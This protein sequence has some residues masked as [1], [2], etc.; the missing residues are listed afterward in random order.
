MGVCALSGRMRMRRRTKT[1]VVIKR[2]SGNQRRARFTRRSER[3]EK[4]RGMRRVLTVL[5]NVG[6]CVNEVRK[7]YV[8]ELMDT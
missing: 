7:K 1:V 3:I 2:L 6:G 8:K 4:R 5:R